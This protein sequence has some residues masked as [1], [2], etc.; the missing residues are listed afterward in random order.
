[1][2]YLV[3]AMLALAVGGLATAVGL[4]RDR[5]FYPTVLIVIASY[6]ALF[7][8]VGEA[9]HALVVEAVVATAFLAVA[10]VG[11]RSSLWLVV[12]ALAAHGILDVFHGQVIANPGVPTWWPAFC[13]T[14]DAV[15]AGYLALLL[16]R[17]VVGVRAAGQASRRPSPS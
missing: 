15:A 1:V 7:A 3:G 11:F 10:I 17:R 4:D 9:T 13:L 16:L 12:A 2:S 14:Y 5:A 6:Y 8:V